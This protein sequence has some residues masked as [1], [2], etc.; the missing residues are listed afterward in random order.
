MVVEV[1]GSIP[2]GAPAR[3]P[4]SSGAI[5]VLQVASGQTAGNATFSYK[6]VGV[7][8]NWYELPFI[9]KKFWVYVLFL[10]ALALAFAIVVCCPVF[11]IICCA[12]CCSVYKKRKAANQIKSKI[13][14]PDKKGAGGI[15]DDVT[16]AGFGAN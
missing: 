13:N 16:D 8:Y 11:S 9:G 3:V 12:C 1:N 2:I 14:S 4:I 15:N 7:K 5:V 6:V 10:V